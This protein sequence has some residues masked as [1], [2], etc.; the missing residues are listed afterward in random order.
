MNYAEYLRKQT[1]NQQKIVG[2][3]NGQ[4]ASQVTYKA[5]ARAQQRTTGP[6]ATSSSKIGGSVANILHASSSLSASPTCSS[7]YSGVADG[8]PNA[9]KTANVMGSAVH[10]AVCSD[11]PSSEPYMVIVPCVT[12]TPPVYNAPGVTKCCKK[13]Y[14]QLFRDNSELVRE[15]GKQLT[16]RNQYN[17]PNKLQGLRGPVVNR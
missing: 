12:T 16:L 17:L 6:V 4:D 13:D 14:S 10:C 1:K 3:Q 2:F 15:Q 11:A 8:T 5:A 7:G 9:D